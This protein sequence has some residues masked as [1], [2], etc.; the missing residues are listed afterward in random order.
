M[1]QSVSSD[2]PWKIIRISIRNG[3][4]SEQKAKR[5]LCEKWKKCEIL[6]KIQK[7]GEQKS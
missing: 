5:S 3:F 1:S 6:E 2:K 7:T 4:W